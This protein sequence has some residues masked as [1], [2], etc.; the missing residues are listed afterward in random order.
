VDIFLSDP[1]AGEGWTIP[2]VHMQVSLLTVHIH[3]P[4]WTFLQCSFKFSETWS[5]N[6]PEPSSSFAENIDLMGHFDM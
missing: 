6:D 5:Q 3:A 2:M 4:V 1:F